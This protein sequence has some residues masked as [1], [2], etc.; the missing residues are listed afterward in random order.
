MSYRVDSPLPWFTDTC[1]TAIQ[2]GFRHPYIDSLAAAAAASRT[3]QPPRVARLRA[4]CD[5]LDWIKL[6]HVAR[7]W[8][9]HPSQV[10][11][12]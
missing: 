4:S 3:F 2:A 7:V 10:L 8:T 6:Q 12:S 9:E 1:P 5:A 11:A